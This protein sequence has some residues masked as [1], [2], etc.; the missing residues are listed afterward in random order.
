MSSTAR[1]KSNLFSV[2]MKN[3]GLDESAQMSSGEDAE[4]AAKLR[5]DIVNGIKAIV[6]NVVPANTQLFEAQFI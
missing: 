5:K 1:H 4:T 3:T 2:K 6:D